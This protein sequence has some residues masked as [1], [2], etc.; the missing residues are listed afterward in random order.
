MGIS[1]AQATFY[2]AYG[3]RM[4]MCWHRAKLP[5]FMQNNMFLN[6]LACTLINMSCKLHN[7]SQSRIDC[8]KI[9][10]RPTC[11]LSTIQL[12]TASRTHS[13]T[14]K[15]CF[16]WLLKSVRLLL[17]INLKAIPLPTHVYVACARHRHPF[18]IFP[19]SAQH[20]SPRHF[21][22][23]IRLNNPVNISYLPA[24]LHCMQVNV[25]SLPSIN[26]STSLTRTCTP[27]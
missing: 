17:T 2:R 3:Q 7:D 10:T 6:K 21:V 5:C 22:N 4:R 27:S 24:C 20:A 9:Y 8:T 18:L 13:S 11:H 15:V 16:H 19:D 23:S 25:N 14:A 12:Q 1:S 26:H